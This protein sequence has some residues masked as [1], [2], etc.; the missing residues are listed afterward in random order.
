M[1]TQRAFTLVASGLAT[2]LLLSGCLRTDGVATPEGARYRG[3]LVKG[4]GE[5][6]PRWSPSRAKRTLPG[7]S[8]HAL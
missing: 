3:S 1:S 2:I 4:N 6:D 7:A 5:P 8:T